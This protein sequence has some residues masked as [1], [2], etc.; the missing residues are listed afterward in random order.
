MKYCLNLGSLLHQNF[1]HEVQ[2]DFYAFYY[3]YLF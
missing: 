3:P 1:F 2:P